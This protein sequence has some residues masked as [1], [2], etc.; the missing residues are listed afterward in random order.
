MQ[1][2]IDEIDQILGTLNQLIDIQ[3]KTLKTAL[4]SDFEKDLTKYLNSFKSFN[5]VGE[6]GDAKA[7]DINELYKE[8]GNVQQKATINYYEH[9]GGYVY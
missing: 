1:T 5:R 7:K 3:Y 8:I 9:V 2:Y 6:M 4:I